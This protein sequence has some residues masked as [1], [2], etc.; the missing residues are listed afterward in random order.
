[1]MTS[2]LAAQPAAMPI[3][4]ANRSARR[5]VS[6]QDGRD[7]GRY[8]RLAGGD[9]ESLAEHYRSLSMADRIARFHGALSDAAIAAYVNGI[10]WR[11]H[12][13]VA[14]AASARI[15]AVAEIVAHPIEGWR[16][17][18]LAL[19]LAPSCVTFQVRSELVQIAILAARERGA[20]ALVLLDR[21]D[22][23]TNALSISPDFSGL[24][25]PTEDGVIIDLDG[26]FEAEPR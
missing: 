14:Y 13:V 1:M 3:Y 18:E 7:S 12:C 26:W 20:K 24:I 6:H 8:R 10:D 5:R 4:A 16:V 11:W 21:G 25:T 15:A 19:S 2:D 23:V 9:R 22:A 17:S